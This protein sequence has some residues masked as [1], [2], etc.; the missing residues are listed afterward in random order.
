MKKT[1]KN[2]ISYF[3]QLEKRTSKELELHTGMHLPLSNIMIVQPIK[4]L[5]TVVFIFNDGYSMFAREQV[6]N[7]LDRVGLLAKEVILTGNKVI[8]VGIKQANKFKT[9]E[10]A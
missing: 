7:Y 6:I 1:D 2:L 8:C 4:R 10:V 5:F 3:S 9:M